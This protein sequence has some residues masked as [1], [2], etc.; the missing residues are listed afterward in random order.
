MPKKLE[1]KLEKEPTK[2]A[3]KLTQVEYE[4]KV[5]ELANKGL[6][7][8]KIGEELKKQ[9]IHSK[10]YKKKISQILGDKYINPDIK[11][12]GEKLEKIKKH[13]EKNEKDKKAI[14]EKDR[15]FS[16]IRKLKLYLN[17]PIKQ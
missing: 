9:G 10:E 15:I 16:Q 1:L 12:I 5:V 2:T 8:E 17:L 7:S 4:S 3:K 14:R 11:N 6:T 13:L